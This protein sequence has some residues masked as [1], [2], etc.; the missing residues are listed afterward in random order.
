MEHDEPEPE[1]VDE[2]NLQELTHW[3]EKSEAANRHAVN[4]Y[5]WRS[6]YYGPAMYTDTF[7][8]K[9]DTALQ[10]ARHFDSDAQPLE[11][12]DLSSENTRVSN[13][14][15]NLRREI[16]RLNSDRVKTERLAIVGKHTISS[17]H[18]LFAVSI[19]TTLFLISGFVYNHFFFGAFGISVSDFFSPSDYLASS[20]DVIWS[21]TLGTVAGLC[22]YAW[23]VMGS[24]DQVVR[25]EQFDAELPRDPSE[26][27]IA[28]IVSSASI[29]L[30]TIAFYTGELNNFCLYTL[31]FFLTAQAFFR[32]PI[33][34]YIENRRIVAA[35]AFSIVFFAFQ[36]WT[37][38]SEDVTR[39]EREQFRSSYKIELSK[40]YQD[41]ATLPFVAQSSYYVFLLAPDKRL[42]V[43]PKSAV[44]LFESTP[45]DQ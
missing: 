26:Y 31:V 14:L 4:Y 18:V 20:V 8:E 34:D 45:Q 2:A 21:S 42:V 15:R 32:I 24:L 44:R 1:G 28:L 10:Q 37:R 35:V 22:Y 29:G 23:A 27:P 43:L 17:E 7:A 40:N 38:I 39:I 6:F 30:V 33:W 9:S 3:L 5:L 13:E 16:R 11:Q 36:L 25:A 12:K 19:F 41:F